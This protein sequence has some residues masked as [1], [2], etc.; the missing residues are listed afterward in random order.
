MGGVMTGGDVG[1]GT[2]GAVTPPVP[3]ARFDDLVSGTA[4][5]CPAPHR[6]LTAFSVDDVTPVLAEVERATAA[7]DWAFGYL[8]YEAAAG[9]DAALPVADPSP[10]DPPLAWFGICGPPADVPPI[11]P[12]MGT[13]RPAAAWVT[14]WSA[15]EHA[16]AVSRVHTLIAAGETYQCNLT[17]RLRATVD[18]DLEALYATLALAQRGAYNAYLDLGRHVVV[19]ASPELFFEW[20]ADRLRTRPMKG[21]AARG[22]TNA[23]DQEQ[24][25]Q[26]RSSAK[27]RAENLMIVDLL[28]NDLSRVGRVGS[29]DVPELFA[30]E[31]Y[32]TVW[33]LTSEITA[34][35]RDEVGLVDVFRALFPCG[36][37]TGA[38]KQRTM[39]VIRDLE[40]GPRGV[41][42]G[43]IGLV[44]P[45]GSPFRARFS[46]AIRTA[47][48]DRVSGAAVYGA[49]GGIT[50]DSDPAAERAEL[51]T[52][53]AVLTA[54]H[55][56][57]ELLETLGYS[58]GHGLR[59]LDRHL[60]R[61]EDSAA[62]FGFPCRVA[63]VR[64]L[65]ESATSGLSTPAK[66]RIRLDRSGHVTVQ[67]APPPS[68]PER[69]VGLALDDQPVDSTSVWLHHK[70]TRRDAYTVRAAR[71]P[72]VDDV[73]LVNERGEITETT[74]ANI[75][76]R[77]GGR[78]W[79]PPVSSAC[80]P[81]VE[82]GRLL[83][84]GVLGERVL[85]FADLCSAEE[86]A[87][88]SSLRGWRRAVLMP[89]TAGSNGLMCRGVRP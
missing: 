83:E 76:V 72:G 1:H 51:L 30:L 73:V 14:D 71:H 48:V 39:Q 40:T 65:L 5:R 12:A 17:D 60:A 58:P 80:L 55:D 29:V 26:L 49:G 36:S 77:L 54:P 24:A 27:E 84:L 25:R 75:A 68:N 9:L 22:R 13:E 3:W 69:P 8:S 7:G 78:W 89:G 79:T 52:K 88:V 19:S 63:D 28:R 82:R 87:V 47:V 85:S 70:T 23:E 41:Y 11:E 45:P 46:V 33:Q 15:E 59:N 43:A 74:I 67:L 31:R 61:L 66:V 86:L 37:V 50:W 32:P 2:P 64:A 4:L 35:T 57:H 34:R 81:G 62:Y 56:D 42:C 21:T 6:V 38:P 10:D 53:A 20:S 16:R 18:G 44:A